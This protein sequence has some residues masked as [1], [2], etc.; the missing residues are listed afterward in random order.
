MPPMRV[1]PRLA[2]AAA[3]LLA[4]VASLSGCGGGSGSTG[5]TSSPGGKAESRPAP[6]KSEFP[7][8]D[9]KTLRQVLKA[10]NG[11]SELV[12]SPAAMVFY[13]GE[14]RYPFGVFERDRTQ[15]PGAEVALYIAKAPAPGRG[16]K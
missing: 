4:G 1:A 5:T 15:V 9:G 16:A 7:S 10:A 12:V 13:K 6:P 14:N 8:A 3:C 11:P 2:L